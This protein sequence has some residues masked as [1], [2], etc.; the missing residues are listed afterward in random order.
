MSQWSTALRAVVARLEDSA[1][2][3][4]RGPLWP[5]AFRT[6]SGHTSPTVQRTVEENPHEPAQSC[7]SI[8]R[9]AFSDVYPRPGPERRAHC[10]TS[11][12]AHC[13]AGTDARTHCH[14]ST[15]AHCHA[16]TDARTHC[17]TSTHAACH[18]NAACHCHARCHCHRRTR[19]HHTCGYER[20]PRT[21]EDPDG[22]DA[23][24][25]E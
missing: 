24:H 20:E 23:D 15:H 5:L 2:W 13:H 10:H 16:G 25:N 9:R 22:Q 1:S 18:C 12:H 6:A 4:R 8:N 7:P 14:T 11:T 21:D 19:G 3:T 17:H